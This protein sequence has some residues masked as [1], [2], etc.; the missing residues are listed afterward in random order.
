MLFD[1]DMDQNMPIS[2][3]PT[4]FDHFHFHPFSAFIWWSPVTPSCC[5][6][7]AT[8]SPSLPSSRLIWKWLGC[9][10]EVTLGQ[11]GKIDTVS[12]WALP[13]RGR[14]GLNACQDG[15]G[16]LFRE[17]LSKFKGAFAC[18]WGVWTLA[19]MVWGTYAVK[20]EVQMAF[21]QVGPEIECP[22]VPVW[23]KGGGSKAIWAMPK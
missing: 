5:L 15:L 11:K 12:I 9:E 21:A 22:S 8:G 7:S 4:L 14:G 16:H 20:I 10:V 18:F 19:R 3:L 6:L 17:E 23:V 2:V 1:I 13:I